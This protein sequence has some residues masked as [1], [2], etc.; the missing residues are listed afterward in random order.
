MKELFQHFFICFPRFPLN[1]KIRLAKWVHNVREKTSNLLRVHFC[2]VYIFS[3]T[4]YTTTVV[5]EKPV[6]KKDAVT[7]KFHLSDH[8]VPKLKERRVLQRC[9]E[10]D[11]N[12]AQHLWVLIFIL[13]TFVMKVN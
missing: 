3:E 7:T 11:V 12:I 4:D 13:I 5:S 2:V 6:L 9:V 10:T 1:D 8:L